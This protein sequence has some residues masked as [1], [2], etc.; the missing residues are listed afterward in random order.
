MADVKANPGLE[1]AR[2]RMQIANIQSTIERQRFE[3]I[4][5]DV[6]KLQNE[7]NIKQSLLAIGELES[8]LVEM[9]D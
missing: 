6:R 8:K 5:M 7:E 2:I 1:Q 9:Q 4:E 3:L